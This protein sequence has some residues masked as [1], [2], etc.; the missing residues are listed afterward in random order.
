VPV[1]KHY[2]TSKIIITDEMV[3]KP[4]RYPADSVLEELNRPEFGLGLDQPWDSDKELIDGAEKILHGEVEIPH[5]GPA[6]IAM[7]FNDDDIDNGLPGW[8]LKLAGLFIPEIL[9]SAYQVT[10]RADFFMAARDV[11]L[12]WDSY[13]RHA[14]IPKGML[15]NDYAI[16]S[17]IRVL[18]KF[19]ILYRNYKD[20]Q[21][22]VARAILHFAARSGQMLAKPSH[23]TF[24]TNHGVI[25]N[26]SLWHLCIAFPSLPNVEY[27]KQ[28]AF[29]R[30]NDQMAFYINDEGVVL[31]HSAGYHRFGL[32]LIA[33]AFRYLSLLDMPVPQSWQEK[34]KKA[35]DFY[36]QVRLPDGSLPIYGDTHYWVDNPGPPVTTIDNNGMSSAL[37]HRMGWLPKQPNSIYPAAGYSVWWDGLDYWPDAQKINQTVLVW[38]YFPGHAHKHADEMS[39]LLYAGGQDWWSNSGYWT[40]GTKGRA[41]AESW[42]GSNA[43]HLVGES[44]GSERYTTLKFNAWEK[45]IAFI[46]LERKGPKEYVARR[47]VIHLKPDLWIILDCTNGNI[48]TRTTTIWTT[49]PSVKISDGASSGSFLLKGESDDLFL[50]AFFITSGGE[51]ITRYRGNERPFADGWK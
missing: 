14:L 22:D 43:P 17:R 27:Y 4:R 15:W 28:L 23:F 35:I 7:P 16:A 6:R 20:Y 12:A 46:D 51:N 25:Q 2:H 50:K 44:A 1:V 45:D 31:E 42:D 36:S 29:N 38:S 37:K 18:T 41:E 24:S 26:L 5:H 10:G 3:S 34:Y 19:W 21:P 48:S 32:Q 11:I 49:R 30:M 47:Q 40:Y 13:D 8:Q 39:V 33:K 9:I